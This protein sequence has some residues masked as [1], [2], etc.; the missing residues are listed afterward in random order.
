LRGPDTL[1]VGIAWQG[2]PK[3]GADYRRSLPLKFLAPL[4]AVPGVELFSLQKGAGTEQLADVLGDHPVTDLSGRLDY[5]DFMM[6]AA[7]I[8]NLDLVVACD[9]AIAHLAGALGKPV[10]LAISFASDWR[11]LTGR[12]DSPWYPTMRI[13]RQAKLGDWQTVSEQMA[14]ALRQVVSEQTSPRNNAPKPMSGQREG[15]RNNGQPVEK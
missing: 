7:A 1:K 15:S 2:N 3:N 13:F 10:W 12:E 4:A 6:T 8:A 11:W 9:T 14:K 5:G